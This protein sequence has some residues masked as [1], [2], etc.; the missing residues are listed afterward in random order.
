MTWESFYLICFLMGLM[1]SVLS[2]LGGMSGHT[3]LLHVGHV[4]HIPQAGH[5]PH[6]GAGLPSASGTE[7]GTATIPW[8]NAF[9]IMIFLCWF[10]AAGY[11]WTR[12]GSLT[13]GVVLV[14]AGVCGLAGGAIVFFFLA[15]VMLPHERELTADETDVVGAVAGPAK[16][17]MNNWACCSRLRRGP[18]TAKRSKSRKRCSSSATKKE[19]PTSGGGKTWSK[20]RSNFRRQT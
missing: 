4:G 3:H 10:G 1:L 2:L 17:S 5:L 13:A 12:H 7:A 6:G 16:W 19:L 8:W 11:L 14:L 18:R 15:K 9:S 20:T